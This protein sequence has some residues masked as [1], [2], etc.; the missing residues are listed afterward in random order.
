MTITSAQLRTDFPEF[1]STTVYPDSMINFWLGVATKL[2]ANINRWGT[3][4]DFGIELF[5]A[6]NLVL[7][8]QGLADVA[9]DNVPQVATG[10]ISGRTVDKAS[11]TYDTASTIEEDGGHWNLTNYGKQF[12]RLA[13]MI[14]SGGLQLT[15]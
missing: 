1:A 14:G 15:C 10:A 9:V 7:Q 2:V 3:L 5:T 8:A 11:V 12:L 13:R 6:H 4:L